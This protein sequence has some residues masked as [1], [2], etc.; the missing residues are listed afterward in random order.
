MQFPENA[1][2]MMVSL[3][4]MRDFQNSLK[5]QKIHCGIFFAERR[6]GNSKM[7]RK[8]DYIDALESAILVKHKCMPTHR[9]TIF[10]REETE[11]KETVWEGEVETFDLAGHKEAKRC[12]AWR[13][14]DGN[15]GVKIFA[16]LENQFI[17][18]AKRAVQAA[19][20]MDAQPPVRKYSKEYS[21]EMELL[22]KQFE[23]LRRR[24][25]GR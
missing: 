2:C 10:V 22:K 16:V 9:E 21:K 19:I 15:G 20:F 11:D 3:S 8:A 13:Y 24:E 4:I 6:T 23:E 17:D 14:T 25:T 18:S 7:S 1:N 12:F 5:N